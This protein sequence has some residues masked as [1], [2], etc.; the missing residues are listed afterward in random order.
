MPTSTH[1]HFCHDR[2]PAARTNVAGYYFG[3]GKTTPN[4]RRGSSYVATL[5]PHVLTLLPSLLSPTFIL[6]LLTFD[7]FPTP[8]ISPLSIISQPLLRPS[9]TKDDYWI[10]CLV[11]LSRVSPIRRHPLASPPR[12]CYPG[13]CATTIPPECVPAISRERKTD[14]THTRRDLATAQLRWP[15]A[16][17]HAST[18]AY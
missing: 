9:H 15:A 6:Y 1:E 18:L 5:W 8:Y 2:L 10:A 16:I 3:S 14:V 11:L 4:D 12:P 7:S 17:Y 13:S